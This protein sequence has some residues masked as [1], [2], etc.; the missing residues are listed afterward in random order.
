MT[1]SNKT[2]DAAAAALDKRP[3]GE[4]KEERRKSSM[5]GGM[6]LK[7][8]SNMT[9]QDVGHC[10]PDLVQGS[11]IRKFVFLFRQSQPQRISS[12]DYLKHGLD[13]KDA[14]QTFK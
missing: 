2:K 1:N 7:F 3:K 8:S 6:F 4:R 5:K 14:G 13:K 9:D 10:R 12:S 11:N